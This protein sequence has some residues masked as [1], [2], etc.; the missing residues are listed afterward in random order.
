MAAKDPFSV[1]EEVK[2]KKSKYEFS[3]SKYEAQQEEILTDRAMEHIINFGEYNGKTYAHLMR[4]PEGR[5]Y[6]QN[7][8]KWEDDDPR[9]ENSQPVRKERIAKCFR[10]YE[11]FLFEQRV[12]E[13][14][15]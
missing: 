7:M 14:K 13:I 9:F 6:L 8:S 12:K 3:I 11:N 2:V 5:Y 1:E 4:T 15:N 10:A